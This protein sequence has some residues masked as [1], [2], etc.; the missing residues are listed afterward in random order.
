MSGEKTVKDH[1]S[2]L[3]FNTLIL[4]MKVIQMSIFKAKVTKSF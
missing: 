3:K 2:P 1:I 4:I